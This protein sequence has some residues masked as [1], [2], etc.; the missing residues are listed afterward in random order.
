MV[1]WPN[2]LGRTARWL[3][4]QLQREVRRNVPRGQSL[5]VAGGSEQPMPKKLRPLTY[6]KFVK[7]NTTLK[8]KQS[9][10]DWMFYPE[11][12][13]LKNHLAIN[14]RQTNYLST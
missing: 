8:H 12:N 1:W 6:I 11:I 13:K 3:L 7:V 14:I 5:V 4:V 10:I 9:K 2:G